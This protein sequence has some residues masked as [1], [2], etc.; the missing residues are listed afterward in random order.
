[1]FHEGKHPI[2]ERQLDNNNVKSLKYC[3]I[4]PLMINCVYLMTIRGQP[5]FL[6]NFLIFSQKTY[7]LLYAK[8]EF[9]W[10]TKLSQF[11]E[12]L[13]VNDLISKNAHD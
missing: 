5:I 2:F 9:F 1:M 12:S 4:L 10:N 7:L 8:I 6:K 13:Y 3:R 11:F